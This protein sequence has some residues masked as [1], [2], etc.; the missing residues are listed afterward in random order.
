MSFERAFATFRVSGERLYPGAVTKV[1]GLSPD[2]QYEK[3]KK[4]RRK[5]G[6]PELTG[7]TNLWYY[8]TNKHLTESTP[9]NEHVG[10]LL[11]TIMSNEAALRELIRESSAHAILTIF[12]S[13]PTDSKVP[14]VPGGLR[15]MLKSIPVK[16][17]TDFDTDTEPPTA[18]GKSP[19]PA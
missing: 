4:Y 5:S 13:G 19:I 2:L 14:N 11:K 7:K 16:V 1:L 12:W 10:F 15:A 18:T 8:S 3:G 6:G 17:E 9:L